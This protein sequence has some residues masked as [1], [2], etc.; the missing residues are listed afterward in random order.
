MEL[1]ECI[2]AGLHACMYPYM[3]VWMH[4]HGC[5]DACVCTRQQPVPAVGVPESTSHCQSAGPGAQRPRRT[6]RVRVESVGNGATRLLYASGLGSAC[7]SLFQP[8]RRGEVDRMLIRS[9]GA[10]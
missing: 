10:V 4:V 8:M 3:N 5:M 2:H 9:G 6:A 7:P 1:H